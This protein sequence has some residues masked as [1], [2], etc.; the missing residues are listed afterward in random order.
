MSR[1]SAVLFLLFLTLII[2]V[3]VVF[4]AFFIILAALLAA[5]GVLVCWHYPLIVGTLA[6]ATGPLIGLIFSIPLY[7]STYGQR[8]FG[9]SIDVPFS[10]VM[11][12]IGI[13]SVG[14]WIFRMDGWKNAWKRLPFIGSYSALIFAHLLSALSSAKPDTLNVI[15]Y[16]LRPV[17]FSYVAFAALPTVLLRRW[18]DVRRAYGLFVIGASL[19]A[20]QGFVSLFVDEQWTTI[21]LHRARPL[22]I[23]GYYPIGSNH[24]VLAEW[25]VVA[26]PFALALAAWTHHRRLRPWLMA[27]SGLCLAI[28]LLT[29][30]RSAW[31]A[32]ILQLVLVFA[33]VW[34]RHLRMV[35]AWFV[36]FA[37]I[38]VVP[39]MGYM[40]W[41]SL[42]PQVAS[43]TSARATLT[44]I[45][46]Q[47]FRSNP[48]VGAGAGT[49]TSRV[50]DTWA[51][52]L[53]FGAPL[54]AHGIFQKLMAETGL[55]GLAAY[56]LVSV[57]IAQLVWKVT[58]RIGWAH[59]TGEGLMFAAVGV[60][61]AWVYQIFNTTY[62]SAKLWLPIGLFFAAAALCR[63]TRY[64]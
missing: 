34:K 30:A 29:F 16:T 63:R 52:H 17:L 13:F 36:R 62:W 50:G 64:E 54:D 21:S 6:L 5:L 8:L 31:I 56:V 49:F 9:G 19:F 1:S 26:A 25:L 28:A 47:W 44:G 23:L 24:N 51:Y 20:L 35:G 10:D 27:A 58:K 48:I 60:L 45:A 46:L 15:K 42:S 33:T 41:F 38:I 61:G 32:V 4:N 12:I 37:W 53:L 3:G 14:L 2:G 40:V 43:S 18:Q 59:R 7:Q 55:I 22:S 39:F 57:T 11:A